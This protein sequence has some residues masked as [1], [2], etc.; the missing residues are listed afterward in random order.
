MNPFQQDIVDFLAR[1][2]DLSEADAA[3]LVETPPDSGLGDYAVPCFRLAKSLRRPPAEIAANLAGSFRPTARVDSANAAG[4]YV[5]FRVN[6]R[7][8]F[9][10]VLESPAVPLTDGRG[11]TV[12]LDYGHP[13][14]AKHL[15]FHHLRSSCIGF[16]L[17]RILTHLGYE[18]VGINHLGDWGTTHGKLISAWKRWGEGIDLDEDGI[19]KLNRLYVRFNEEGDED[20][21]REWFLR[22]EEGDPEARALWERFR[23][24]SL[25]EF[26]E[27]FGLLGVSFDE[28]RGE[29]SF[30]PVLEETVRRVDGEGITTVSDG[31]LVVRFPGEEM[32]PLI[33]RKSDGATTYATRDLAAAFERWEKYEFARCIYVVDLGQAL[34]FK[35]FFK[36]L[37]MMGLPWADRME[38]AGFGLILMG[39]VKAAT[40]KGKVV[41][42]RDVLEEAIARIRALIEEKNPDLKGKDDVARAVGV[43]AIIFADISSKRVKNVD[44]EWEEMLTFEGHTGPYV[45]YTHARSASILRKAP[46]VPDSADL[47][48]LTLPDEWEIAKLLAAFTDRVRAAARA[49][50]PSFVAQYLLDLSETFSRYYNL[51][52]QDPELKVLAPDPEVAS[53]RLRLV[54]GV[55]DV[56]ARGLW[57]LGIEAPEE[58]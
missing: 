56:L 12:V 33:L 41:L 38:H 22:L 26:D 18:T 30:E 10:E 9:E 6:R 2:T 17:K 35:Q 28:I 34:H 11:K 46:A 36:V 37:E 58:M 29:A 48:K 4:P 40:R 52:N 57:L 7:I 21:G 8:F 24:V 39:G 16:S 53:A 31:A 32:T 3:A 5:N 27:I 50:E 51:G 47:G 54:S 43:G 15:G 25:G 45:Q 23:E 20:E 14:I 19:A 1:E 55:R 49:S 13:N 42:L 44:F